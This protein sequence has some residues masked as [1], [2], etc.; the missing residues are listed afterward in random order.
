MNPLEFLA[1]VLPS[2][3]NGL[4]CAAELSSNKK[5][6][7]FAES[8][9]E[10]LPAVKEWDEANLNIFF[11]LSVFDYAVADVKGNKDRRTIE[12][13]RF[14]KALFIDLDGYETKKDA[15]AALD[16]FLEG[17]GLDQL[18]SPWIMSS[19]GG[20]HAYWPLA[21]HVSVDVW[22][23][24]A[25]NLKRLCKQESMRIDN[26]VTADSAR[27]LR[28]P[29]TRNHKSKYPKPRPIQLIA[30]GDV[31]TLASMEA[32]I[33]SKLRPEYVAPPTEAIA[34]KRLKREPNAAQVKMLSDSI[35]EFAPIWLRTEQGTGCGQLK[36]Y[37][38]N[39]QE[40][41]LEPIWRG[42]LSWTKVCADGDDFSV[43]ISE[44]HPYSEQ[45]M[46]DK[47]RDIKGPYAC[48]KMD[49]ENPGVCPKCP[50]WNKITNPLAMGRVLLKDN[51]E[52]VIPLTPQTR[53]EPEEFDETEFD[54]DFGDAQEED[55]FAA[56]V[57]S[58]TRPKPPSG[59][60]FGA[61]GGV[62]AEKED[63]DAQGNKIKRDVQIVPYDLFVVDVLQ[64]ESDCG[65]HIVA[66]RPHGVI[67]IVMPQ[68]SVASRDETVKFLAS[69]NII[70]SFG[71]G[72]DENLYAYIRAC[73][74][75]ASLRRPLEVPIQ[76]GWQKDGSFV[77]NYRVFKQDGSETAIPMPGLENINRSTM[78]CGTLDGWR[79][80]INMFSK[81][82][83]HMLLGQVAD[84]FGSALMRF[85]EYEGFVW[86][87]GARNSGTGKSLTLS[88]KAGV[89]GHPVRYRTGKGTSPV[90]MQQR[91][92][93]LNSMPLLIDEITAK[94]RE[95]FEWAPA[96][97][98]DI[99][100]GQ[101]KERMESGSN[102]ER[103]N[104]ST[105]ALTCT[106]TSNTNL[107]DYMSG[108]RTHSSQGELLRMLEWTPHVKLTWTPEER[109][110]LNNLKLHYGV[111]GEAWVRWLVQNQAAAREMVQRVSKRLIEQFG[112]A[113][114]ER[115]WNAGC[116]GVVA[117]AILL[118][119]KYAGIINLPVE[120]IVAA[121][122]QLVEKARGNIRRSA[123][124]AE[125]V[126]N[127]YTREN[128]GN[129]I[130]IRKADGKMLTAWGDGETVDKS[131]TKSK[132][133]G[134]VEHGLNEPG[135]TEYF[136][137]EQLM[138]RH[139]VAMSYG[140]D[141]FKEQ[142]GARFTTTFIKKDMMSRTNGPNMRVNAMHIRR[143]SEEH[144][145]LV[146]V[147]KPEAG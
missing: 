38:D 4:Y 94:A 138:K 49:S 9:E 3:G 139:C 141:E 58:V 71:K 68:K 79:D 117:A 92:G 40:D 76:C 77:Y 17:T 14:I 124:S 73:V 41:G 62:Y 86:H 52:K 26:S 70:A 28:F 102:R 144:D 54:E 72:N 53:A 27:V 30:Q 35:T 134:R 47:L 55:L 82:Q 128:Y 127:A 113:D 66:N 126:L 45:R 22:R 100:E 19:G 61:S 57:A 101:G 135:W 64:Q 114:D 131:I 67:S 112:F 122:K 146:S 46:R 6:H 65:V 121:L 106:M 129:F 97:I 133:L 104:N 78:P 110:M 90:A 18:G 56:P 33:L 24:V 51:E 143:R 98:F 83:M 142:I 16:G 116:T 21:E 25:E 13:S 74:A 23:P 99:T 8:L 119:D 12:N 130:V 20:L 75:E 147:E 118:G 69:Q 59:F 85:T 81:K 120:G 1:V 50:H 96:F 37:I 31:F 109:A 145:S 63:K 84:S 115:Y 36:A 107:T 132:V 11:A 10:L 60:S 80:L 93:L 43:R 91:A 108:A 39:P 7:V 89:W 15:A 87:I 2:P 137:E 95:D 140:Y 34:G 105:W 42:L 103:I 32:Q 88:A 44:M 29:G 136:I 125:D 5:E 111:A 48:I 123:V